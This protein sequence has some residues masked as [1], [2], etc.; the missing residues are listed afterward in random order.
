MGWLAALAPALVQ[1]GLGYLTQ[2]SA[3]NQREKERKVAERKAAYAHLIGSMGGQP[4]TPQAGAAAAP[5]S[6]VLAAAQGLSADP[7]VKEH[8][9]SLVGKFMSNLP[10]LPS[11][12]PPPPPPPSVAQL[13]LSGMTP[14]TFK[15][16]R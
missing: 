16:F 12:P 8:I 1:G 4:R 3:Q 6:S 14:P 7:L 5:G 10:S 2:R 11:A 15:G 9:E 13:N